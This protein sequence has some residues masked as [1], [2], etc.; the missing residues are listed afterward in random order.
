MTTERPDTI[1]TDER[2][3][4]GPDRHRPEH[5]RPERSQ[6]SSRFTRQRA[7]ARH[8]PATSSACV[9]ES[10]MNSNVDSDADAGSELADPNTLALFATNRVDAERPPEPAWLRP[11]IPDPAGVDHPHEPSF[12]DWESVARLRTEASS[13]LTA[14]L[15][16]G[17]GRL[18]GEQH[19]QLGIAVIAEL[20]RAESEDRV[21]AGQPGWSPDQEEGLRQALYDAIFGL[22]RLQPLVDDESLEN[23]II[24]ARGENVTV[25]LESSDGTVSAG[26]PVADSEE[27]LREFLTDLGSRQ[28]RPFTEARPSL[29]LR[30]PGGARL[31]AASWVT[32]HTSVVIRRH[33]L[34]EVSI[35]EMVHQREACGPVLA[36]F[37]SACVRAGK[38]IVVS[39]GQG[40]G[41]TTWVRA[42]C[43]QIPS[44]EM[45]GTF[46]TEFELH[47]HEMPHRHPIVH[48]WEHRPGSGEVGVDGRQAGQF[49]LE[50]ALHDSFRFTLDRQIVGEVRGPEVWSMLKAMESGPGSIST[51][52]ARSAE[53]T[54]EKLVSCAME[55]GPQVTRELAISKLAAAI[56]IVMYLHAEVVDEPDGIQRKR[57]WV[58]EVLV[59]EPSPDAVIGYSATAVFRAGPHGVAVASGELS[60]R[61][62]R[63]LVVH[64]FD[65]DAYNTESSTYGGGGGVA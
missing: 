63:D 54:V 30:L 28:N 64:G 36:N 17:G 55:T 51:T 37:V 10:A 60:D 43:S 34:V 33:R 56:D 20:I 47:L 8:D 22:G 50:E 41:K 65:L 19:E 40:S 48:A 52:H 53:H 61:L 46:E 35:D 1:P 15:E 57:R 2:H 16:K 29:H 9:S 14:R 39:G 62:C 24:I 18:S 21:S 3:D 31:A 4:D 13:R 38:S 49:T 5:E 32:A 59:V 6:P 27:E 23:I 25:W 26:P 58:Q 12:V 11:L 42:L 45:I 7:D 44:H